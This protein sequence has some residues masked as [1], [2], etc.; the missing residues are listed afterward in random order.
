[1]HHTKLKVALL[2]T[3]TAA[4]CLADTGIRLAVEDNSQVHGRTIDYG[5]S[6]ELSLL[7]LPKGHMLNG[8]STKF[9]IVGITAFGSDIVDGINEAG[10]S[11]GAFLFPNY[12]EYSAT[13]AEGLQPAQ[14]AA[15]LLA[16][17]SSASE[18]R[19]AVKMVTIKDS[20]NSHWGNKSV[21][22]HWIIYDPAGSSIVIE[23]LG[24]Q[25]KVYDNPLGVLA[26]SP[27]FDWHMT[28]LVNYLNLS[29][30]NVP[31][32]NI[33]GMQLKP[34]GSGSGLVGLPG[35]FSSPSR[36]VRAAILCSTAI[37]PQTSHDAT[38]LG[39]DLLNN[40]AVVPGAVREQEGEAHY[41]WTQATVMRDPK[42]MLYLYRDSDHSVPLSIDVMRVLSK[43]RKP[44][45][46]KLPATDEFRDISTH[47]IIGTD[48]H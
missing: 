8:V 14:V 47:L 45:S 24:G 7:A 36:F 37:L 23:P 19:E 3:I 26:N 40:L 27:A 44:H 10:L 12:A 17:F 16:N 22:L 28:N 13:D 39:F 4:A 15:W 5:E 25:L 20:V 46:Y 34:F 48:A 31:Q 1:M 32:R 11:V 33:E 42:R 35:D 30:Y 18:I 38:R 43:I 9:G 6:L 41:E 29:V 2:A 21:P